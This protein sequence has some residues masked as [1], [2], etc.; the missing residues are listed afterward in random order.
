M[1]LLIRNRL[2]SRGESPTTHRNQMKLF[3]AIATAAVFG[4]SF[5][6]VAPQAKADMYHT[7]RIGNSTYTYGSNGSSFN[8]NTI[9]GTTFY[10]G[11]TSGGS[12]YSGSCTT[13][14]SSTFCN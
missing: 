9:G 7:N 10:S 8:T 6:A 2:S 5:I 11:T 1:S 4:A 12:S 3:T 13:I 14:G